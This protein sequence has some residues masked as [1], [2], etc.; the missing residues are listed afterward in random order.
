M[1]IGMTV[2]P[3]CC[4]RREADPGVR[5]VNALLYDRWCGEFRMPLLPRWLSEFEQ[6]HEFRAAAFPWLHRFVRHADVQFV[7]R[8]PVRAG[9]VHLAS[10]GALEQVED[11]VGLG[12]FNPDPAVPTARP[13]RWSVPSM[14]L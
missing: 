1:C 3:V 7:G 8:W 11:P 14:R 2:G 9:A 6:Q 12:P 5:S 10:H 4:E 13:T